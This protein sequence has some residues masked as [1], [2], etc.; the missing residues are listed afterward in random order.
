MNILVLY[1][2]L[3]DYFIACLKED[4]ALNNNFFL[5]FR[6]NPSKQAPFNFKSE[7]NL[8][9]YNESNFKKNEILEKAAAFKPDLVYVSGWKY[10]KYWY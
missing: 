6:Y 5:V 3:S 10:K 2:R 4:I 9:I 1:S 7:K 8:K